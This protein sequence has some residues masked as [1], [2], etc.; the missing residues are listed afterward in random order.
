M[1]ELT[2][3][4]RAKVEAQEKAAYEQDKKERTNYTVAY[5]PHKYETDEALADYQHVQA[6]EAR[7]TRKAAERTAAAMERQAK[8]MEEIAANYTRWMSRPFLTPH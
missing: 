8:A 5:T 2:K 7:L 3:E 1:S 6:N 4:Q